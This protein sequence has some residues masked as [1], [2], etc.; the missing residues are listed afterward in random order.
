MKYGWDPTKDPCDPLHNGTFFRNEANIVAWRPP[1]AEPPKVTQRSG[2]SEQTLQQIADLHTAF[3]NANSPPNA[4][5]ASPEASVTLARAATAAAALTKQS[6]GNAGVIERATVAALAALRKHAAKDESGKEASVL[7]DALPVVA[8]AAAAAAANSARVEEAARIATENKQIERVVAADRARREALV[9][10][11]AR[12][13]R[14]REKFEKLKRNVETQATKELALLQTQKAEFE[15][16]KKAERA[17][18]DMQKALLKRDSAAAV[19]RGH[20]LDRREKEIKQHLARERAALDAISLEHSRRG[21]DL[22]RREKDVNESIEHERAA[23]DGYR[24]TT[25]KWITAERAALMEQ[26]S[27]Q[28]ANANSSRRPSAK[29]KKMRQEVAHVP[30][31]GSPAPEEFQE[32]SPDP[33]SPA[34]RKHHRKGRALSLRT[35]APP[36]VPSPL[37]A[38]SGALVLRKGTPA[39]KSEAEMLLGSLQFTPWTGGLASEGQSTGHRRQRMKVEAIETA[40][41]T[42]SGSTNG[43]GRGKKRKSESVAVTKKLLPALESSSA[44]VPSNAMQTKHHK[45]SQA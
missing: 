5:H 19:A 1:G 34:P 18:L 29:K 3:E 42:A 16:A 26:R 22:D 38:E 15:A 10:A 43:K 21:L 33:G 28:L 12:A 25:E 14:E 20:D 2:L 24:A 44:V 17:A 32:L 40:T 31:P 35:L 6:D 8:L 45:K 7:A 30:P 23:L 27:T 36:R 9:A 39:R 37:N 4:C 13:K 11:E 41:A